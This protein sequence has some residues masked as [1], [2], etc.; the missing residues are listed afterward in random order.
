MLAKIPLPP[1]SDAK[2]RKRGL[3]MVCALLR[4]G[5]LRCGTTLCSPCVLQVMGPN[6]STPSTASPGSGSNSG[7]NGHEVPQPP[8]KARDSRVAPI[9]A[10]IPHS[11][12]VHLFLHH[13][14]LLQL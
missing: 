2:K 6:M 3:E 7:G 5:V 14:L 8:E 10:P 9:V 13:V 11:A 4:L 12:Q 1:H